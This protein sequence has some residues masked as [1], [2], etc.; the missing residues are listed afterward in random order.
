MELIDDS[1]NDYPID[2]NESNAIIKVVG[3]GGGGCNVVQ[4]IYKQGI[5]N[6]DLMICNTDKQALDSNRVNE[7]IILGPKIARNLGAGCDPKKG[8][9]A[10]LQSREEISK[11]LPDRIEMVFVTACLGGGTGTGAAPVIAE[12]AKQKGKLV[13]GV[14]TIP[15]RDEGKAFM[16]RAMDGL[17]DLRQY[18]DSLLIIDNQ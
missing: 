7:K 4:E 16:T 17:R 9:E 12:I 2:F 3:V 11:A 8:R 14:V 1:I 6:V 13:V 18:V 5:S 10:A 15:F